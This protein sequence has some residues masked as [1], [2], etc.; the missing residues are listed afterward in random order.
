M[1]RMIYD[2]CMVMLLLIWL[3]Y[4][5]YNGIWLMFIYN[6]LVLLLCVISC[7]RYDK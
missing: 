4:I 2:G 5:I 3:I 7:Y 6:M 1:D